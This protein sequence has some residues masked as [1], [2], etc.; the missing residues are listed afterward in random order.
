[1][2]DMPCISVCLLFGAEVDTQ[3]QYKIRVN[4]VSFLFDI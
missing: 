3:K 1:M 4:F 2:S